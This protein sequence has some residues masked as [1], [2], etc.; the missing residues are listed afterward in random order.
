MA[1]PHSKFNQVYEER[2]QSFL[3]DH[4]CKRVDTRLPN[5]WVT[6]FKHMSNGNEIILKG[7]PMDGVIMQWTNR[8]FRHIEQVE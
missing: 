6:K 2:V 8:V 1:H 5:V 3:V 4:Y 7:Y